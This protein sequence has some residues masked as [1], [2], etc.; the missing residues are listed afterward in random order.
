L[1]TLRLIEYESAAERL[2]SLGRTISLSI[3]G[4]SRKPALLIVADEAIE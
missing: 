3:E 2:S 4:K 1:R